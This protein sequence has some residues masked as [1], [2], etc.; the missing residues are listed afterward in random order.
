MDS[1]QSPH[2]NPLEQSVHGSCTCR[3]R[4]HGLGLNVSPA[5]ALRPTKGSLPHTASLNSMPVPC[6]SYSPLHPPT[7]QR[8][9]APHLLEWAFMAV[10]AVARLREPSSSTPSTSCRGAQGEGR[11]ESGRQA[12]AKGGARESNL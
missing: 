3:A 4:R 9:P 5:G 2:S 10:A 12:G 11:L 1:A 6:C 8:Q 7:P